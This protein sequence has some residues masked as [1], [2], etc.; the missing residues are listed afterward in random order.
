MI[1]K[2]I[3]IFFNALVFYSRIPGPS[4][5]KHSEDNL[6]KATRYFPL[7]GWIVGGISIITF[8]LANQ[9]LPKNISL[10]LSMVAGI[11]TTGGFHEDGF[12]DV[13]DGF[14]GGWTKSKILEIMKDSR[15][16]T[17]GG[18]GLVLMLLLKFFSLS[19]IPENLLITSILVGHTVSRFLAS[20][21]IFTHQYVREDALS[22]AKPV[23]KKLSYKNL[24]IAAFFGISPL[25]IFPNL[26]YLLVIIPLFIIKWWLGK[27]FIKW[28][29][30]YTGDC[31]GA[32]QQI[33]EIVILL[34]V[35]IISITQNLI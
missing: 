29:G 25:F 34:S 32:T 8:L 11:L 35:I 9:I 3:Q 10:V 5:I 7:I 24:F 12:A 19:E 14:G 4:W 15:V 28:I 27:Y 2:E 22:K 17:Y 1:Q 33:S 16:G 26:T 23:A 30:G 18:L 6:N 13:C 21:F 20:S 31:L